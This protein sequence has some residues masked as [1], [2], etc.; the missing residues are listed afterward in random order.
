MPR[1][2]SLASAMLLS[3]LVAAQPAT[4]APQNPKLPEDAQASI[5]YAKSLSK[6]FRALSKFAAPSVVSIETRMAAPA[7]R[8]GGIPPQFRQFFGPNGGMPNGAMPGNPGMG[9]P[10]MGMPGAGPEMRGEGTGFVVT[11]DG[12]IATNNHV[13]RGAEKIVVRFSDGRDA[14][15]TVVGTDA[16]TDIAV[17]KVE[18][19]GL[20]PI[21]FAN[22]DG[23]EVGDWVIALGSPF[24]LKDSVTAG[25]ISAKGREVG[26]SPLE[27]YLQ[28]D[29]QI[30]PGNSG[31][32][33]VDMDGKVVGV[34][35]AIESRSGGSDGIGFAI[36]ANMAK[37]V[38]ESI[39]AG[40]TPTRGY[41]GV[42]LQ[43]MDPSLAENFGFSGQG[44]L[45]NTVVD[46]G[47]AERAGLQVGD[48]IT[49]VNGEP[50]PTMHRVQRAIRLCQP[51][52][53][54]PLEI[55]R[56]GATRTVVAK[57]DD[58]AKQV[59][60]AGSAA[61]AL[62]AAPKLAPAAPA[63][64]SIGLEVKPIDAAFAKERGLSG[65]QGVLVAKVEEGSIAQRA[66]LRA[67]DIVR[68]VGGEQVASADGFTQQLRGA[69]GSGRSV[70]LLVERDGASKFV[71]L[72]NA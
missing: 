30:N 59:A 50:T 21:E 43:P 27:S 52:A 12:H 47:P 26:L 64:A 46:A 13:V 2:L 36:P 55:F 49:K 54:C 40:S 11:E 57:L 70:R 33:L 66:G 60:L 42:Q 4:A 58:S 34:N 10:G 65:T 63:L 48:I 67:G 71:L 8:V 24:G 23:A 32:P 51:G 29:A 7:A 20:T 45:V 35:T 31:G 53:E 41:L 14:P 17:L 56:E 16:E 28:T 9:G 72:R 5:A 18:L 15:A 62:R 39:I 61:P 1:L 68:Q 3:T 19:A 37:L 38:V 69:L 25:I 6:A 44:V 22:S